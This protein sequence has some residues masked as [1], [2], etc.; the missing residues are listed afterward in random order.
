MISSKQNERVKKARSL[1]NKK[2]R[3]EYSLYIAEGAKTVF[4]AIK[5]GAKIET[6]FATETGLELLKTFTSNL[7]GIEVLLV[8]NEVYSSISDEVS[9]QGVLAIIKKEK[10][11]IKNASGKCLFLDGVSDPGNV[12]AIIR[13]ASASGF[14]EIYCFNVADPYSPKAVR[15]SMSGIF[16]VKLYFGDR[17]EI[18]KSVGT[19]LIV[20]SMEGENAFTF[21]PPEKFCLVIGN[22]ANG[23]SDTVKQ[24]ADYT[25]SIPMQNGVESLNASVSAG[26]LMYLTGVN[27]KK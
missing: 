26:I 5:C 13:T 17:E 9:P 23:V 3:D 18:L 24:K 22:E 7:G 21:N 4:E 20:A 8:S 6:I 14:N 10:S 25:V 1:L 16:K 2:F 27:S 11:E 15:S 12:G 19:S